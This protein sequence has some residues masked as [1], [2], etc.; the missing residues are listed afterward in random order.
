MRIDAHRQMDRSL[1]L[2]PRVECIGGVRVPRG[3]VEHLPR[4]ERRLKQRLAQ[5]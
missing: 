4:H 3:Y 5:R 1:S 2:I